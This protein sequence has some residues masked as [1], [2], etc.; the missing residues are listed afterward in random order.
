MSTLQNSLATFHGRNQFDES[1]SLQYSHGS[2]YNG[3]GK[4]KGRK[5]ERQKGRRV[6]DKKIRR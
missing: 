4:E 6:E 3:G 5:A 2:G 1:K